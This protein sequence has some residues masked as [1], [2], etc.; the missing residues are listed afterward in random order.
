MLI[1]EGFLKNAA[2]RFMMK[3]IFS[4]IIAMFGPH[5]RFQVFVP[6]GF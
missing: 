5:I 4:C 3:V 1:W 6:M 2:F